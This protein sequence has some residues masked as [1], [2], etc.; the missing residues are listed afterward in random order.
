MYMKEKWF[1]TKR[2]VTFDI[3]FTQGCTDK[4]YEGRASL[5]NLKNLVNL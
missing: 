1:K 5:S 2:N 4:D 3:Y